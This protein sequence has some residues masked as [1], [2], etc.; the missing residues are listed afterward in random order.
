MTLKPHVKDKAM[1]FKMIGLLAFTMTAL[2]ALPVAA[3]ATT[4]TSPT[5]TAKT[6][7]K[8]G[9]SENGHIEFANP[10]ANISCASKLNGPIESHGAGVTATGKVSTLTFTGCTNSWH[11]TAVNMGSLV[12]HHTSGYNATVTSSGVRVDTTRLGVT[13]VYITNN[14][15]IGTA[16]GGNPATLHIE[17]S[18]PISAE[19]SSGLCGSGNS[20]MEGSY[21]GNGSA[22]YD[23]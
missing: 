7:D 2:V 1:N 19:E 18:I 14:T 6:G 20:K 13:C 11:V 8:E 16:T 21:V 17:A 15:P 22:Y 4:V 5:G 10:I 9:Q 23:A 12:A 3:Q